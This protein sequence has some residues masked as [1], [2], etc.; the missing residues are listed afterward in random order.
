MIDLSVARVV[1]DAEHQAVVVVLHDAAGGRF[2]PIMVGQAEGSAIAVALQGVE[3]PRPQTH[4]LFMQVLGRLGATLTGVLIDDVRD[5]T[6]LAQIA[7]N[8]RDG[9][10]E[11]DARPSD[12]VALA[13]RAKAPIRAMER[14]LDM[15]GVI[16]D[17]G[18]V[19]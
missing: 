13:L 15:A 12:A 11:V 3:A 6:F 2:L 14:V 7:L 17:E 10:I 18:P 4:D 16:P 1:H 5:D 9:V 19:Q 8:T